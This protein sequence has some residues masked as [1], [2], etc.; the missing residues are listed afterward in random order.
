MMNAKSILSLGAAVLLG[1][2]LQVEAASAININYTADGGLLTA[3]ATFTLTPIDATH[4][5]LSITLTNTTVGQPGEYI[6]GFG[7][8]V[9]PDATVDQI[10]AGTIFTGVLVNV[11]F[12]GFNTIDV[13]V[14]A[15]NNCSASNG[16]LFAPNS[17]T[18]SMR[19]TGSNSFSLDTFAIKFAGNLGSFES[20]GCVAGTSCTSVPEP[21]TLLLL[22]SGSWAWFRGDGSG[23][24]NLHSHRIITDGGSSNG[25][26]VFVF[27]MPC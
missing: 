9:S 3:T 17:D 19:L 5:N 25:A 6:S 1:S 4:E 2:L 14:F 11:N 15:G 13:C 22:S 7:F 18:I 8:N 24:R 10:G 20:A 16:G 12:P 23:Q 21:S 26:A 27:V